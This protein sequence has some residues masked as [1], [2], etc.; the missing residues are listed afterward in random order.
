MKKILPTEGRGES[1][2]DENKSEKMLPKMAE[3][4]KNGGVYEQQ[5]RCGKPNCRCSRGVLHIGHYLFTRHNGKLIKR[6]IR[7]ADLAVFSSLVS[8]AREGRRKR[9]QILRE[10]LEL[11]KGFR[12]ELRVKQSLINSLRT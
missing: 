2:D 7:K 5:V 6:Y 8:E 4:I 1:E 9:R 12:L 10:N 3:Q 11:L